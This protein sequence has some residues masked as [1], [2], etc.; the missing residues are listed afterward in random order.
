M[1]GILLAAI[2]IVFGSTAVLADGLSLAGSLWQCTRASD[3]SQF[4][5]TFYPGSAGAHDHGGTVCKFAKFSRSSSGRRS[6]LRQSLFPCGLDW[7]SG[8]PRHAPVAQLDR[9]LDYESAGQRLGSFRARQLFR[10]DG[11]RL[12]AIGVRVQS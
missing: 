10:P 4:V 3:R 7:A 1:R 5:I 9:A 6:C 12:R 11:D 8:E 2:G